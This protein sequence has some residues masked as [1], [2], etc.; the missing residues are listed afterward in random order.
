MRAL[1]LF[2]CHLLFIPCFASQQWTSIQDDKSIQFTAS[3]DEVA[4]NGVFSK[5]TSTISIDLQDLENSYINCTIDVTSINTNSRDRDQA[6]ADSDWF[7]FNNF[8]QASFNST[9]ISHIEDDRYNIIGILQ[10]RD[11]KKQITFPL[12]WK[13][14]D[15]KHAHAR[16]QFE[17]DRRDFNIGN[18]EWAEDETI[19]FGVSVA[20][21]INYK[22]G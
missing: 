20:I 2:I 19:G 15:N 11:Q 3:Y 8:P 16:A 17:L 9:H 21:S 1:I 5:S 14:T 18:G 12:E 6:L 13:V 7:Y 22:P 4:F 10:I